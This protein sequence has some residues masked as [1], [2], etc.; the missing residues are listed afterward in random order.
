MKTG[1]KGFTHCHKAVLVTAK[2]EIQGFLAL[3]CG[4]VQW[5]I[6]PLPYCPSMKMLL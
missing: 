4:P 1:V 2:H 5:A 6:H 3:A